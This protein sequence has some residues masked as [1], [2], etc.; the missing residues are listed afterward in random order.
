MTP[1]EITQRAVDAAVMAALGEVARQTGTDPQILREAHGIGLL[2]AHP[3]LDEMDEN[4]NATN[5]APEFEPLE[6][7][8]GDLFTWDEFVDS[9]QHGDLVN[10][11]GFGELATATHTSQLAIDPS[12]VLAGDV[13]RPSWATHVLWYNR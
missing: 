13:A 7:H 5:G 8:S 9:C 6:G 3:Y 4:D 12:E 2:A 1:R 10:A 11:D